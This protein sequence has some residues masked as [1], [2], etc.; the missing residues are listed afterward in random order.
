M[1]KKGKTMNTIYVSASG[2]PS[3]GI[4]STE[5]E[6]SGFN[7][8]IHENCEIDQDYLRVIRE[9]TTRAFSEILDEP[10]GVEFD[11]EREERERYWQEVL[12]PKNEGGKNE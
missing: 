7:L 11:F 4:P 12:E 1:S 2:D 10:V 3:V 8:I 5:L 6:I 9:E